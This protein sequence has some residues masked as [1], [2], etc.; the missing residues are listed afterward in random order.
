MYGQSTYFRAN[1]R[2]AA[3]DSRAIVGVADDQ[4]AD[5]EHAV[6]AEDV[7]RRHRG[8]GALALLMPAVLR[9]RLQKREVLV[10]HV[11]D[12]EKHVAEAGPPHQRRQRARRAPRSD[13][14]IAWTR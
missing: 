10:E 13:A 5:D 2:L 1:A 14:V 9:A 8:V 3:I 4:A 12:A 7:D 11:L 6:A